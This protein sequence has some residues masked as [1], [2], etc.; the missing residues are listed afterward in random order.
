MSKESD[1]LL[2][3]TDDK[4]DYSSLSE[5]TLIDLSLESDPFIANSSLGELSKRKSDRVVEVAWKVIYQSDKEPTLQANAL[6]ILFHFDRDNTLDY[7]EESAHKAPPFL[8][9]KIASLLMYESDFRYELSIAKAIVKR[10]SEKSRSSAEHLSES[11]KL[12]TMMID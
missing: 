3:M 11:V 12:Y 10:V 5:K 9:N 8:L 4:I 6:T 7:M 1:Y 2:M